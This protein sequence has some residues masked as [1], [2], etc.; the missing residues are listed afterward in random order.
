MIEMFPKLYFIISYEKSSESK[1]EISTDTPGFTNFRTEIIDS[2]RIKY[3]D[4]AISIKSFDM[5]KKDKKIKKMGN[6][7]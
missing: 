7:N 2:T 3:R 6:I 1:I 4:Y 5:I